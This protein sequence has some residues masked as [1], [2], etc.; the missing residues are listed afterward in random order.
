MS[1]KQELFLAKI[2]LGGKD[3]HVIVVGV[4]STKELALKGASERWREIFQE[5]IGYNDEDV[6]FYNEQD[7]S[8]T[9]NYMYDILRSEES[10]PGA[11]LVVVLITVDKIF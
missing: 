1:E 5:T 3:N 6:L 11:Y 7:L 4:F 2:N 8:K 10:Y 9:Q